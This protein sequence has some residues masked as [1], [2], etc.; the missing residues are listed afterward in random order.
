MNKQDCIEIG[1]IIKTHGIHGEL[2]LETINPDLIKNMKESVFLEID[3]L[4]V[5]FFI[6]EINPTSKD[7][8]R[9]KFD[10]IDSEFKAKKLTNTLVYLSTSTIAMSDEQ[11]EENLDLLT[12]FF[13]VDKNHG[14]LG[15]IN[16]IINNVNNPLLSITYKSTELLIPLHPDFIESIDQK[17][18]TLTLICPE[19]LIDL[20]FE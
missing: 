4:L 10:W 1:S 19:G 2:I 17:T 13:V 18:K 3:G 20:Y 9:I 11:F 12:G 5:P 14:E 7:R 6:N 15:I 8:V 16:E